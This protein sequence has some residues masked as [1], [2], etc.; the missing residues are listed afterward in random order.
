MSATTPLSVADASTRLYEALTKHFGPR[1]FDAHDPLVIAIAEYGQRSRE[2]D[3]AAVALA[4][5]HVYEAMTHHQGNRDFDA[6]DHVV[7]ALA[8]FRDACR[9]AGPKA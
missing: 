8:D 6:H 2:G 1:D 5:E 3:E 4:S 7:L 9:A